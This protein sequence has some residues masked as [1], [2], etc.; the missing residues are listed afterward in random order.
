MRPFVLLSVFIL[1]SI[2]SISKDENFIKSDSIKVSELGSQIEKFNF[3]KPDSTLFYIQE[4]KNY[5]TQENSIRGSYYYCFF[6]SYYYSLYDQ[7]NNLDSIE[8]LL[9]KGIEYAKQIPKE[10]TFKQAEC[11]YS[12]S[13]SYAVQ[14]KNDKALFYANKGYQLSTDNDDIRGTGIMSM[15]LGNIYF[16]NF[17]K[18]DSALIYYKIADSTIRITD[19]QSKDLA[20]LNTSMGQ[21]F[22]EMK[23]FPKALSYFTEAKRLY[24]IYKDEVNLHLMRDRIAAIRIENKEFK[25]AISILD[26]NLSYYQ[27]IDFSLRIFETSKLLGYTYR[28]AEKLKKA[29][30]YAE[31]AMNTAIQMK[32]TFRI[33]E[34]MILKSKFLLLL[35]KPEESIKLATQANNLA[36]EKEYLDPKLWA[37]EILHKEVGNYK[38][39]YSL[40]SEYKT[41]SDSMI[42]NKQEDVALEIEEKYQAKQ[43]EE[44]LLTLKAEQKLENEQRKNQQAKFIGGIILL[45]L[46]G[47]VLFFLFRNRQKTANKLKELDETKTRFFENISHEFRTPLTLIKLPISQSLKTKIPL[48]EQEL[49]IMHNNSSRL[50]N[51][52]EDLLSLSELDAGKMIVNKE[53]EQPLKQA[54]TL[55]SQFDSYATSKGISYL[56]IVEEKHILAHYDTSVLDKV[57]TNLISNAIK[58]SNKGGEVTARVS[59]ENENLVMEISDTGQGISKQDQEKIFDRFYQVGEKDETIQGSGIGLALV[60]RVLELNNGSISV[61]SELGEG[62]TFTA[63]LPLE[64]IL[65]INTSSSD[66][67]I[68]KSKNI[69]INKKE[70]LIEE[71]ELS[72]KPKLLIAEDNVELADY[73]KELFQNKYQVITATNGKEGL[74]KSIEE[75]PDI[76]I[77]DWMMPEMNGIEFL[78]EIKTNPVTSHIPFVLLTAKSEVK[79][80]ITGYETGAD[81][82]FGKPFNFEELRAQ[83][84][85][86]I[87]LRKN[88][89]EKYSESNTIPEGVVTNSQDVEFWNQFKTFLD[90]HLINPEL[91]SITIAEELGM[92]RMQLH[93]K[94]TA[95]TGQSAVNIIRNQRMIKATQLLADPSVRVSEVCYEVGYTDKSAFSRSF[96]KEFGV[97]PT[98]FQKNLEK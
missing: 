24:A 80:K 29:V 27:K 66:F 43:K 35:N 3:N 50:Q 94:L 22:F 26:S 23:N 30:P 77:S 84:V 63:I 58:Y 10:S 65:T 7:T 74:E 89:I 83:I 53:E 62:S 1:L 52:I 75:V 85:N 87:N 88:L 92:S 37:T 20:F 9:L 40:F 56:K 6:K 28:D 70:N 21:I 73:L 32:D 15:C 98:Q 54:R 14:Y 55:C 68:P 49:N 36:K 33:V 60:K 57:M 12:L 71:V 5:A 82:Y 97:T 96:K 76:I 67:D 39:A 31:I 11:Y 48:S 69:I 16:Y 61:Q 42:K 91:N 19:N 8:Y 38:K 81:A 44:E 78:N 47:I 79:D 46:A 17:R 13:Y 64:K 34:S 25:S 95:L 4:L 18:Y 51:L 59:L 86:L 2:N 72:N 41:L 93:R 45:V 90:E